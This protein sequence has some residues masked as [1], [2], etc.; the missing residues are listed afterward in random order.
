MPVTRGPFY[1]APQ[2]LQW[3]DDLTVRDHSGISAQGVRLY[4]TGRVRDAYCRP[5][6]GA[7]VELWQADAN[8]LYKHVFSRKRRGV[9]LD[10]GFKYFGYV[11]S[12][13]DGA[14]LFKTIRPKWYHDASTI[15]CAHLHF[16]ISHPK[17]GEVATQM[18]FAG[19]EED[20]IRAWDPVFQNLADRLQ[21]Q[22]IVRPIPAQEH[23]AFRGSEQGAEVAHFDQAFLR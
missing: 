16:L 13:E 20:S 14:Y 17:H 19:R 5:V 3:S 9:E 11:K 12:D 10:P 21:E 2:D 15:R 23:A 4:V 6:A 8:G 22:L 7:R 1:P 18:M